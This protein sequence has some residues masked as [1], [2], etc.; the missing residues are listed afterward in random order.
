MWTVYGTQNMTA[1]DN[2]FPKP[3][4]L[5]GGAPVDRWPSKPR[6][7]G[8]NPAGRASSLKNSAILASV[9]QPEA[10]VQANKVTGRLQRLAD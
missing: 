10:K 9:A 8:S 7:A 5:L 2:R 3:R 6:V 1:I 4:P